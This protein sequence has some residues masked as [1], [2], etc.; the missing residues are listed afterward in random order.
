MHQD[1]VKISL[2]VP[3]YNTRSYL[4]TCVGSVKAQ[5]FQDWELVLVDDGSTDGSGALCDSL[6]AEDARIR[7]LHFDNGGVSRARNRG[8][9]SARGEAIVFLDSDDRVDPAYL[10]RLWE[11]R[12]QYGTELAAVGFSGDNESVSTLHK[13][14]P[15]VCMTSERF[16]RYALGNQYGITLSCCAVIYPAA[17]KLRFQ[18][19]IAYGEDSLFFCQALKRA[20]RIAYDAV[21]LYEYYTGREGNTFTRQS[22]KKME[23][24]LGIW[25]QMQQLF[26]GHDSGLKG[27]FLRI[28][29][30]VHLQAA[31]QAE[32]E[33]NPAARKRHRKE[34]AGYY[35]PLLRRGDVSVKHKLRLGL[36]LLSPV[37]GADLWEGLQ[38]RKAASSQAASKADGSAKES[39]TA[40]GE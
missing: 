9:E 18:E 5:T 6:A 21:P 27:D 30:D 35:K 8:M 17:W 10:A 32:K 20:G 2:I 14:L 3:V 33:R 7:A 38:K 28:L 24:R 37:K 19:G 29:C 15:E 16:L 1:S 25:E 40:G 23:E 13:A 34:A 22:L 4:E 36:L 11:L 12:Q 39:E 26:G 31:R